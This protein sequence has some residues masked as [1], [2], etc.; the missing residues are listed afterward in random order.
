MLGISRIP[1]KRAGGSKAKT[2]GRCKKNMLDG[3]DRALEQGSRGTVKLLPLQNLVS[4]PDKALSTSVYSRSPALSRV[5]TETSRG[6]SQ[7]QVSGKLCTGA[8]PMGL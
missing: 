7:L 2:P 3:C 4:Q 6:P 8:F 1:S 5:W